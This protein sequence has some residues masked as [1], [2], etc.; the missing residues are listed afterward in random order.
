MKFLFLYAVIM[1]ETIGSCN[2]ATKTDLH[3]P[4]SVNGILIDST[5]KSQLINVHKL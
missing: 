2:Q 4:H 1:S 3:V 5:S